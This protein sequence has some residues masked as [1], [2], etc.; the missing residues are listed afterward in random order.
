MIAAVRMAPAVAAGLF[1]RRVTA[2]AIDAAAVALAIVTIVHGANALGGVFGVALLHPFWSPPPVVHVTV[3]PIG[4]T[5]V[6]TGENGSVHQAYRQ[7]FRVYA[8]GGL[9]VVGI[10]DTRRTRG[11]GT[12]ETQ[13][14]DSLIGRSSGLWWRRHATLALMFVLPFL[15]GALAEGSRRQA[16]LGKHLM[17]LKVTD[18]HG[19]PLGFRYALWRQV[20]KLAEVC[21]TG[22]G[23]FLA[24]ATERRQAFHDI[25]ARTQVVDAR[26]APAI[27]GR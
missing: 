11:D 5:T 2:L 22:F 16:T 17:G 20:M 25:L 8:D 26:L 24:V 23:Y 3:T 7:E 18:E 12:L 6:P 10:I 4:E 1:A 15:Y 19:R 27:I 9:D 14:I 13:S 21:M